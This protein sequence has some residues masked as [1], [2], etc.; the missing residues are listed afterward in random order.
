ARELVDREPVGTGSGDLRDRSVRDLETRGDGQVRDRCLE[1]GDAV[2]ENWRVAFEVA[3]EQERGRPGRQADH[4]D[5]RTERLD[6]EDQLGAELL[7]EVR[8]VGADLAARE[9][10]EV[11]ALEPEGNAHRGLSSIRRCGPVPGTSNS[12]LDTLKPARW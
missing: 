10:H 6:G 5:A 3:G 1:V 11:Q 2:D 7:G 4:R 8:D 12:S 9:V